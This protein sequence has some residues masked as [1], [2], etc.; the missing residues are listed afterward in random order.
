MAGEQTRSRPGKVA[1]IEQFLADGITHMFGNPGTVEQG[2]LDTADSFPGFQYVLTLQETVAA[3]IADGYARATQQP[4]VLQLHSGVGLGNGIGMLYQARRGH[5]PLVV[6]AG[7]SGVRYDSM[8]AQMAA[9]LVGMARPVTKYATRV[10][11]PDSLLRVVRRA[12]KMAMTPPR[13]PVFVSLPMD[14]LDSPNTEPALPTVIPDTRSVPADDA[15]AEAA[16]LLA[17][18]RRPCLLA[19]DGISVAGAEPELVAIAEQLGADVWLVDSSGAHIPASHPLARGAT[20]HMF[21][22]VSKAAIASYDAF[23]IVG[24]YVFPEV[25]PE[26]A[27]PFPPGAPVVH[28]DLDDYEVGKNHPVDLGLIAD[29]KL[30]LAALSARLDE[31]RTPADKDAAA[32][33]LSDRRAAAPAGAPAGNSLMDAFLAELAAR[34]PADLMVFDEALT[35]SP[36]IARHLQP[37]LPGHY[38]LTRGGSLGV[39]IP[40]AVGMKI[41]HP[42]K[43]VVGFTGDGGSMYTYQALWTAARYGVNASFVVCNNHRYELLNDNISQYWRERDIAPHA[44]PGSFQLDHPQID[45]TGLARALGAEAMR[46]A[47]PQDVPE[48]VKRVVAADAPFLIDLLTDDLVPHGGN[49]SRS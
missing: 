43:T 46:V 36:L 4:T 21:G 18:A 22:P 17:S 1:L 35:A 34:A 2:F 23:L 28:I 19:G 44:Y 5:A 9:D 14:V 7:E 20:G 41:A 30:A 49:G 3:G 40:G 42:G 32:R 15:V 29:P 48:A 11:D 10:L 16:R 25:F 12:I 13:G 39:G 37:S 24:T 47:S 27:N 26:L 38:F 33:R 8:D 45:F 31:V 6:V